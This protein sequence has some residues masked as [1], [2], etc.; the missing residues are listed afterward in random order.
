MNNA[1]IGAVGTVVDGSLK[2]WARVLDVNLLGTVRV[3]RAALPHLRRSSAAAVVMTTSIAA[4]VGLPR[5]AL[6]S[7]SKGALVAL[8]RA[9]AADHL[10]RVA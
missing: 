7:A 3:S 2:E 4:H 1:G 10:G 5:R 9:M 6:Y 8:F